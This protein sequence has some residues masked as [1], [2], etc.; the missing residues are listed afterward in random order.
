M[1]ERGSEAFAQAQV[2]GSVLSSLLVGHR[3]SDPFFGTNEEETRQLFRRDY[4]FS[5]E[6]ELMPELYEQEKIVLCC[7]GIDTLSRVYVNNSLVGTTSNMHR[8]YNFDVKRYLN[9]G[10]NMVMVELMSP[11]NYIENRQPT[12]GKVIDYAPEGCAK[13]NQYL[14]KAHCMFGWDWGANI[15]DCGIWRSI[16]LIGYSLIRIDDVQIF[17]KHEKE[18]H[19]GHKR[20]SG[21]YQKKSLY[22]PG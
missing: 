1:N 11:L 4:F 5:T 3:I 14:R 20:Q 6:F 19:A 16:D 18:G 17:Q 9:P 22:H 12:S 8:T 15:P 21:T 10:I 7:K 2:P 13:G